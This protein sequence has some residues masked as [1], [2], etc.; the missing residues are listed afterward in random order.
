[1]M[2]PS[3]RERTG[4]PSEEALSRCRD[5]HRV[6]TRPGT[7]RLRA[8]TT[9]AA[10]W[11]RERSQSLAAS[12][13]LACIGA[14]SLATN[15]YV[16][17]EESSSVRLSG[18][19]W[20]YHVDDFDSVPDTNEVD[21]FGRFT[22]GDLAWESLRA[23]AARPFLPRD[24]G[25]QVIGGMGWTGHS[26][27]NNYS[28]HAKFSRYFDPMQ[29]KYDSGS[30]TILGYSTEVGLGRDILYA[31]GYWAEGDFRPPAN[32]GPPT[33]GPAGL[34]SSGAGVGGH[35]P[36][37]WPGPLDST[38]FVVG[39]Q[40]FLADETVNWTVELGHRQDLDQDRRRLD[41][42]GGTALT[43]QAR[44]RFAERFLL[45]F[46]AYYAIDDRESQADRH[47]EDHHHRDAENGTYSSALRVELRVNF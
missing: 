4:V 33:F 34:S 16:Q 21:R 37:L 19:W 9:R 15:T 26:A 12:V 28:M 32:G 17:M 31:N 1:M 23:D 8:T 3:C 29:K 40:S 13:L 6:F 25:E 10:R 14:P 11:M 42:S 30:L 22:E 41:D 39:M 43:T 47:R 20:F 45:Q 36:A 27:G 5:G 7:S 35:H 2:L 46:D 44:Y 38:G 18:P 24:R